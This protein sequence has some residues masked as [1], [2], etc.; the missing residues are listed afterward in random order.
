MDTRGCPGAAP[1]CPGW[2]QGKEGVHPSRCAVGALRAHKPDSSVR[3]APISQTSK[4][5]ALIK[6]KYVSMFIK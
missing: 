5:L 1:S 6:S 2:G 3:R 4:L